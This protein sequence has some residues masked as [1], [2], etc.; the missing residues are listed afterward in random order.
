[1]TVVIYRPWRADVAVIKALDGAGAVVY[2]HDAADR[3][4]EP[5]LYIAPWAHGWHGDMFMEGEDREGRPNG[6]YP[7]INT[8]LASAKRRRKGVR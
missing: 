3:P 4:T 5:D 1:M 7:Y 6:K 8:A 2:C